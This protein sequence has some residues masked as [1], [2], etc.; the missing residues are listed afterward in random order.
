MV[1][2]AAE[3]LQGGVHLGRGAFKQTATARG[4]QGVTAKQI[5]ALRQVIGEVS[6]GMGGHG[7]HLDPLT[8]QRKPIAIDQWIRQPWDAHTIGLG[9]KHAALG[10]AL[11]QPRRAADVVVVV[12]GLQHR[13]QGQTALLQPALQGCI[14]R[15]IDQHGIAAADERKHVVVAQHGHDRDL[16]RVP[17]GGRVGRCH[18]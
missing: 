16:Q 5:S 6:A 4:K 18:R 15:G 7:Q 2:Q 1:G 11:Q 3:A 17:L 12:M 8:E 10:P 13:H 14:H 9:G